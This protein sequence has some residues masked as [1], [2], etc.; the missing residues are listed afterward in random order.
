MEQMTEHDVVAK[1]FA[2]VGNFAMVMTGKPA[3]FDTSAEQQAAAPRA[4]T[5]KSEEI[6]LVAS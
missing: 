2:V 1:T 6:C 5:A 3:G 4:R